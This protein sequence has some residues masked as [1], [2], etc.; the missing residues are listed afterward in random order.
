MA[1]VPEGSKMRLGLARAFS[2]IR[3]RCVKIFG[4]G[5]RHFF[6]ILRILTPQKEQFFDNYK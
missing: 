2:E 3:P 6:S 4:K 1:R 5:H